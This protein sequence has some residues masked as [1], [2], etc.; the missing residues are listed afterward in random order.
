MLYLL[1]LLLPYVSANWWYCAAEEEGT[2]TDLEEYVMEQVADTT[3]V[4]GQS[5]AT[6]LIL[7]IRTTGNENTA[8]RTNLHI[9]HV[10][11]APLG[12]LGRVLIVRQVG[13]KTKMVIHAKIVAVVNI[14]TKIQ[15]LIAD[16]VIL[17]NQVALPKAAAPIAQLEPG[18]DWTKFM[19]RVQFW[20]VP[21][22]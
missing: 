21:R 18:S 7:A 8:G 19:Q 20:H 11:L 4:M 1:M 13:I 12:I 10:A 22:R 6:I 5:D 9:P 15:K 17:E 14:R 3:T 16:L 2:A